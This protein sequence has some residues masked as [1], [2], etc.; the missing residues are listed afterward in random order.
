MITSTPITSIKPYNKNPRRNQSAVEAVAKS[1]KEFGFLQPIVVD[2][3]MVIVVGHTR[4]E[5]AKT[6]NLTEVPVLIAKDLSKGQAK[7]YRVADNKVG[8]HSTWDPILL[9][10]ELQEIEGLMGTIDSTDFSWADLDFLKEL[11]LGDEPKPAKKKAKKKNFR[12]GDV[13]MFGNHEL[14][15]MDDDSSDFLNLVAKT[16][17]DASLCEVTLKDP[18]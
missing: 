18:E 17:Q 4:F 3:D 5:A 1:I 6:L 10:Q 9:E 12:K 15:V 11:E 14:H 16:Y 8:E 2:K 13:W 7:A